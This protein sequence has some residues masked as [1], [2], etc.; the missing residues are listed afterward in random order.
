MHS[1]R[2]DT[3]GCWTSTAIILILTLVGNRRHGNHISYTYGQVSIKKTLVQCWCRKQAQKKRITITCLLRGTDQ[4]L[5][6]TLNTTQ[7][8]LIKG[9][10]NTRYIS[11][12]LG[13]MRRALSKHSWEYCWVT[14]DICSYTGFDFTWHPSEYQADMLHVFSSKEQK[15]GD[16]FY[17]HVPTFLSKTENLKI[18]EWFETLN[19]IDAQVPRFWH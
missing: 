2:L 18:L 9:D 12:Y 3:Y 1:A 17:V 15:F 8:V 14:T 10:A 13:T 16:T 6:C 11:D 19:F 5:G 4:F 7:I